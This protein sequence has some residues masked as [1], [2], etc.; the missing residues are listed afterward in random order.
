MNE[1]ARVILAHMQ[2]ETL[3]ST[4]LISVITLFGFPAPSTQLSAAAEPTQST[5]EGS[6]QKQYDYCMKN[7]DAK[8]RANCETLWQSCIYQKCDVSPR[9]QKCVKD[10]DC[11]RS[12][13]E[14]ASGRVG[15]L[16]CCAT[17]PKHNNP[18]PTM[19]DGKC[20]KP[21]EAF[22]FTGGPQMQDGGMPPPD[23]GVKMGEFLR[24]QADQSSLIKPDALFKYPDG[25]TFD[26]RGIPNQA[27]DPQPNMA[28]TAVSPDSPEYRQWQQ[29]KMDD[30][31]TERLPPEFT[32]NRPYVP[33]AGER[34]AEL[35]A[36]GVIYSEP[37]EN[38][39]PEQLDLME[40][41]P[42]YPKGQP[43]IPTA[44]QPVETNPAYGNTFS[45]EPQTAEPR[46]CRWSLWGWCFWH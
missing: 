37:R 35:G 22:P 9:V 46:G 12:C 27:P 24:D 33:S 16:S 25:T 11:Q 5:A 4:V 13:T 40:R 29:S 7:T 34:V 32:P 1:R 3:V 20:T 15:L 43:N 17:R 2:L 41:Y 31:V 8:L 38:F 10:T 39:A 14:A 45:Y 30:P 21:G 36:D 23:Q 26:E 6:C 18:C 42:V 19:I 28:G 44:Q